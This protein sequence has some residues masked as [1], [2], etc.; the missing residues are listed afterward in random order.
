[1]DKKPTRRELLGKLCLGS[2][3]LAILPCEELPAD[4][5]AN[6]PA[7]PAADNGVDAVSAP[8][9][10]NTDWAK[11]SALKKK[12][13]TVKFCGLEISRM[14]FG[15]GPFVGWSHSR[16][17][18]FVGSLLAAYNTKEKQF[19]TLKMAEACGI[20]T[21][22]ANP[23]VCPIVKEYWDKADGSIQMVTYCYGD[24]PE[25]L[26]ERIEYSI[27]YEVDACLIQGLCTDRLMQQGDTKT[28]LQALDFI[29]KAGIPAGICAHNVSTF[30][31]LVDKKIIPDFWMKTFHHLNYWS[32]KGAPG[33]DSIF[34]PD[35]DDTI[36]YMEDRP[37]PW[38]A[39][40]VLAGGAIPPKDGFR[41]AFENGADVINVGMLDF[42]IVDDVNICNSIL[43]SKLNRKRRWIAA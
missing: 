7:Q 21:I 43:D 27:K 8:T 12:I 14:T 32:A 30:K 22:V 10:K 20:N 23:R 37:E 34:C 31:A 29:H 4:N 17:L 2:A 25:Q 28:V 33:G 19:A 36:K 35:P 39:F 1:M 11:F 3:A 42:E 6:T 15:G 26:F 18:S 40:K 5:V 16:D 38:I 13:P 24:K 41:W 9:R